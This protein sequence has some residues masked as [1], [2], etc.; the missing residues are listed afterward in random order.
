MPIPSFGSADPL[1][2]QLQLAVGASLALEREPGTY[3][4]YVRS[5]DS[6]RGGRWQVSQHGLFASSAFSS[7]EEPFDVLPGGAF[8]MIRRH[9][10]QRDSRQVVML[11]RW[12]AGLTSGNRT[13]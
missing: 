10:S 5:M 13:Q 6:V 12:D 11:E 2:D 4:L 1:Y 3:Q 7:G 9:V 8:L